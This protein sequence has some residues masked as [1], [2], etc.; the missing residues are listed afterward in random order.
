M[1]IN[2][3]LLKNKMVQRQ[4]VSQRY[5][6]YHQ[7]VGK[8]FNLAH[9]TNIPNVC[10]ASL[11]GK[12]VHAVRL[13]VV[14]M[15]KVIGGEYMRNQMPHRRDICMSH[16]WRTHLGSHNF[17]VFHQARSSPRW[18]TRGTILRVRVHLGTHSTVEF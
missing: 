2:C 7:D 12:L 5:K 10:F 11:F 4:S 3:L 1:H 9:S 18:T 17:W 16:V 13:W 6:I 15:S 8:N 14:Y